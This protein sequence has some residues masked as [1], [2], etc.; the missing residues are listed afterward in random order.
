MITLVTLLHIRS[1]EGIH[2]ITE[3]C[4]LGPTSPHFPHPLAPYNHTFFSV[5]MSYTVFKKKNWGPHSA[6]CGWDLSSQS[7][8][9]NCTPAVETNN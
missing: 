3:V 7:R 2:L 4:T 5:S 1:Q 9:G 8:D 6:A